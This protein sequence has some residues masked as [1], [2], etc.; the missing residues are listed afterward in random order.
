MADL[1][2]FRGVYEGTREAFA[3]S[4]AKT[5]ADAQDLIVFIT[6]GNGGNSCIYAKGTFFADF[7]SL[8]AALA[9]V[10]GINVGDTN[11]NA[12]N[13]GGYIKFEAADPATV[14]YVENNGVKIGLS[15]AFVNKVNDT[16]SQLATVMSDYLTSADRA[17]LEGLIASAKSE[18]IAA[19]VGNADSDTK[20]S[21]TIEGVKKYVDEKTSDIASNAEFSTLKGRVDTIEGDYLKTADKTELNGKIQSNTD[22]IA[23]LNGNS[24]VEGSVDKK[25]ADAIN[26]FAQKVTDNQT[27]D[28][29]KELIDYA[30]EHGAEF[31]ELVGEV[32]ANTKAIQTLNGGSSVAGS[33]DKKVADAIAAEEARANDLYATKQNLS[34]GVAEAKAHAETK[35]AAAQ[36]AAEAKAAELAT[37]AKEAAIADADGKLADKADSVNVYTK[38][39]VDAMFAWVTL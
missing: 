26:E 5:N 25:V 30:A 20:D 34:D 9:F 27:I 7:Q 32:D 29:F 36:S 35:A 13:G 1:M 23:T 4:N 33:V 15:S 28:T 8:I 16:A 17:A 14:V 3:T 21:K 19:V 37:A 6:G 10:K 38:T 12:A 39:E 22:A 11:Y 2:K 31:A 18:A 24:S